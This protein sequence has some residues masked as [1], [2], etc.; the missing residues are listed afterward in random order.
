M[1]KEFVGSIV[2]LARSSAA[3]KLIDLPGNKLLVAVGDGVEIHDKDRER[4]HDKLVSLASLIDWCFDREYLVIKVS[5]A[6]ISAQNNREAIVDCDSAMLCLSYSTA[7]ADLLDWCKTPRTVAAT[8]KGLRSK[9]SG[10]HDMSYLS[11]FRRLDFQR[12]NDGSKSVTH[13]G[14]SMGKMVEMAAQSGA[15]E[16]PEVLLFRCRL[17]AG[18]PTVECDLRFAVT[19]DPNTE[20]I[21]LAPV[22]DCIQDA[23][24]A[25]RVELVDRLKK[26]F[27]NALVLESTCN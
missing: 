23:Q 27:A 16:I 17:F 2:E 26:E 20:T 6:G 12:K 1:L 14:E 19:V 4:Y 3:P 25:T 24:Q 7:Y 21:G 11:V 13:T 22:G 8:V 9:L 5:D 15:G 18:I 10:T